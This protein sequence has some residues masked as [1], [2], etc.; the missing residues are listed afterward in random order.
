MAPKQ[1]KTKADLDLAAMKTDPYPSLLA[2][3]TGEYHKGIV[4][5]QGLTISIETPRGS[6]RSGTDQSGKTWSCL[7]HNHYGDIVN[8]PAG[9]DGDKVDVFL[10]DD[11]TA[12]SAFVIDQV[13]PLSRAFDEHKVVLGAHSSDEARALYQ[14][15]YAS[16][17]RGSAVLL[18]CRWMLSRPG[19]A[20]TICA[21]LL[22][23][24]S[25]IFSL[26]RTKRVTIQSVRSAARVW[27]GTRAAGVGEPVTAAEV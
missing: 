1:A 5:V 8:G 4:N 18:K 3:A 26:A 10:G 21:S 25:A 20:V 9:T 19:S 17:W 12:P 11:P 15:N 24:S 13:D 6:Y 22:I 16:G 27:N 7:L 14:S 23:R 2:S